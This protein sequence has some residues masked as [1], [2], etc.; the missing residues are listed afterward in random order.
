MLGIDTNIILSKRKE[1][2]RAAAVYI[3]V[4]GK[5]VLKS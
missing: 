4:I 2:E 3:G 5:E 1:P